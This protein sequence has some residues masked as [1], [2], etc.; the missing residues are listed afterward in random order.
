MGQRNEVS[1]LRSAVDRAVTALPELGLS[2][3]DRTRAMALAWDR[4]ATFAVNGY[5]VRC[6]EDLDAEVVDA[7]VHARHEAGTTASTAAM[8]WRRSAVRLLF[9]IW[10]K[11]GLNEGDPTLDLRLPRRSSLATRPLTDD[12]GRDVPLGLHGDADGNTPAGG[13]GAGRAG[14][15][16]GE[17]P[18]VRYVDVDVAAG[19]AWLSGAAKTDTRTVPLTDWGLVQVRRRIEVLDGEPCTHLV[20]TGSGPPQSA[21]ASVSGAIA[22]VLRRAGLGDEPDV[23]PRSVTAW[24]GRQSSRRPVALRTLPGGSGCDPSIA[25]PR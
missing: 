15:T 16:S 24:A 2:A 18:F 13:V 14:A 5:D 22:D 19:T 21:Q 25:P 6:A 3:A 10:R 23:R 4:F 9:R 20:Y 1:L 8:H 17:I 12:E 7:F 11:L